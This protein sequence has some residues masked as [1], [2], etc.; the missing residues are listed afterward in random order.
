MQLV[1]VVA[2]W[3]LV[4]LFVLGAWR[5]GRRAAPLVAMLALVVVLSVV[6]YGNT[7]FREIAEPA[8]IV[9]AM[10]GTALTGTRRTSLTEH[11]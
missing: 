8:L 9:G 4:A 2:D 10:A 7:R 1:G 6:A 11:S 3:L 5:L